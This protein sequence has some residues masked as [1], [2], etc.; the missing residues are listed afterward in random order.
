MKKMHI[1]SLILFFIKVSAQ[2]TQSGYVKTKGRVD[3]KGQLI[4]GTRIGGA[5]VQLTGGGRE[6]AA[7][8]GHV[9]R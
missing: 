9:Y 4:P 2:S 8:K 6:A 3:S 7:G 5:T 1:L